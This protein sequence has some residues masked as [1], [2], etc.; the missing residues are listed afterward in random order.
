MRQVAYE[1]E[2]S[3]T[4]Y[5]ALMGTAKKLDPKSIDAL[6]DELVPAEAKRM[7]IVD[8]PRGPWV[9][10]DKPRDQAPDIKRTEG[11]NAD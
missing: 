9:Q 6:P 4:A 1:L 7:L 5:E 10:I 8:L 3:A 11:C 2:L